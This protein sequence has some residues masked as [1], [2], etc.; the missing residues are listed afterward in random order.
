MGIADEVLPPDRADQAPVTAPLRDLLRHLQHGPD[1]R[2]SIEIVCDPD[3]YAQLRSYFARPF[4]PQP[5]TFCL[6]LAEGAVWFR[7]QSY[8]AT[9]QESDVARDATAAQAEQSGKTASWLGR[10]AAEHAVAVE[11]MDGRVG[12]FV[13]GVGVSPAVVDETPAAE[14]ADYGGAWKEPK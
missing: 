14:R 10:K 4:R 8:D 11:A 3:A 9:Y 1:H 6:P 2:P 7:R 5:S 12:A 13:C